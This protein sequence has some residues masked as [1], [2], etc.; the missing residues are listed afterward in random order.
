MQG[1][2]GYPG[3]GE[4]ERERES[5]T[6]TSSFT[7]ATIGTNPALSPGPRRLS[8]PCEAGG[9]QVRVFGRSLPLLVD[10]PG[11][12]RGTHLTNWMGDRIK[13]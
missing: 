13:R 7:S 4:R 2:A 11:N 10:V 12:G 5:R 9:S 8:I 1:S 6:A 3:N